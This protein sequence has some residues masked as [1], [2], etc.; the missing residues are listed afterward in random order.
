MVQW[1]PP[2]APSQLGKC[3]LRTLCSVIPLPKQGPAWQ[4]WLTRHRVQ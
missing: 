2:S 1:T 4:R 3:R